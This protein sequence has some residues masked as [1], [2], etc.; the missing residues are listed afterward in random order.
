MAAA[1]DPRPRLRAR[2]LFGTTATLA[3]GLLVLVCA[4]TAER[5]QQP[6]LA[7]R[8]N[9]HGIL[10]V[11]YAPLR[12]DGEV[13]EL[14]A[15]THGVTLHGNQLTGT[16]R[17]RTATTYFSRHAGIGLL[18]TAPGWTN[19]PPQR[20]GIIGLGVGS[21][22]A[23]GRP[24]DTYRFYEINPQIVAL[25]TGTNYF[26]Y[27]AD[28]RARIEVRVG[29]ARRV[30]E[31]EVA[32]PAE[33]PLDLLVVD[34]YSG[35]SVP[36]HLATREAFALY[37]RRLAPGGLL[38]VHVTNNY[39]DLLPLIKTLGREWGVPRRGIV[40]AAYPDDLA[41]PAT[42]CL[43]GAQACDPLDLMRGGR[44][45]DRIVNWNA[46]RDVPLPTD[47]CG[48][49]LHLFAFRRLWRDSVQTLLHGNRPQQ[50]F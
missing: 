45:P 25:A 4:L 42:W 11:W 27:L 40:S 34:A 3:V 24:G 23:Y 33:P 44:L 48:S 5:F 15:L 12:L 28:S 8:R 22:A 49:L 47:E 39:L 38:A 9:F 20:V 43:L 30:L 41:T 6:T 29:D 37:R 1:S 36:L 7:L 2:V 14:R 31:R 10:H 50:G 21:L 19:R 46:V 26:S 13:V 32:D 16:A 35:D 17:R 18:L